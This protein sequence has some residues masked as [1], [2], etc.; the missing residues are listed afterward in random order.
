MPSFAD[1]ATAD[2]FRARLDHMIDLRHELAVLTSHMPW[3]KLEATLAHR[4]SRQAI[5]GKKLPGIDL[6]G[7]AVTL[8]PRP[9]QAGRPRV[10]LRIMMAL[11]YLQ[12]AFN[13]SDEAVVARWA[14]NPYWQYFSG[15]AYFEPRPPCDGSLLVKFRQL[16]GEEGVEELLAH[17]IE[18]A[19]QLKLIR[20]QD[21]QTVVVDTTVQPKAIAHPTDSRLLEVAR[22]KLVQAAKAADIS[23]K[24][25]FVRE[26]AQLLRKARGYA[27]ARQFKRLHKTVR[28]QRTVLGRLLREVQRKQQAAPALEQTALQQ[29]LQKAGQLHAQTAQR[30]NRG[31]KGKLYAWHAPEVECISK[32]KARTPYEFGVKAGICTTL[33]GNLIVGARSFTGNPYD[34]HTL[35]EQLE[36]AA[37]LMQE[38]G[39]RPKTAVVDLG[40]R[41]V[42]ALNKGV[43]VLHRGKYQSLTPRQRK[44]LKRRQ[45][46]EPVIGHLKAD[47]RMDRCWYK[48]HEGDALR[49]VLS[50]VGF[51]LRWLLRKIVEKGIA[52]F[53]LRFLALAHAIA[54]LTSLHS[55]RLRGA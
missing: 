26:G 31:G 2:F 1:S 4:L 3:Q 14:E 12:N 20:K 9:S 39:V 41:G 50:A 24:Q 6:F 25:T 10:P 21:L 43:Q 15:L 40:Y 27:H 49:T 22:A 47:H 28:R 11:L 33:K 52:F 51:N 32:G 23:L 7:E 34:G 55:R 19:V 17:T 36:Q 38:S 16:I 8:T 44:L 18:L 35:H 45:S 42:D 13:L 30:A 48:G 46:I 37:I 54:A 5:A 53:C 29:A